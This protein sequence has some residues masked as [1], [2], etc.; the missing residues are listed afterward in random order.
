[1]LLKAPFQK[2]SSIYLTKSKM[3]KKN[4]IVGTLKLKENNGGGP[5]GNDINHLKFIIQFKTNNILRI[6]IVDFEE[7]R[8]QASPHVLTTTDEEELNKIFTTITTETTISN[9]DDID[10]QKEEEEFNNNNLYEIEVSSV[11]E[12]FYFTIKRK[13][14]GTIVFTTKNRPFVFSDQYITFG[15]ELFSTDIN[16]KTVD[17]D[18]E[19]NNEPNIYGLG[20]RIDSLRL[21]IKNNKYVMWNN[22]NGNDEK[23]N[24][25]GTHPFYLQA[26]KNH[27]SHGVFF[28]NTNAIDVR[29]K[30]NNDEKYLQFETIGGIIDL[31]LFL[32]PTNE[33]VIK[34]YH[35]IIGKS[36][37]PPYW[38]LGFHQCKWGYKN[39]KELESVVNNY[40]ENNLPLDVIWSDIDYMHEYWDFTFD[41]VNYPKELVKE[42]VNDL[43]FNGMK[44]VV[45]VDP[46][47]P[48][49][50]LK[51]ESYE[52]LELGL[53]LDIFIKNP[54][55]KANAWSTVWPGACYFPDTTNPNFSSSYWTPLIHKFLKDVPIDGL[56]I[57]MNE[58]ATFLSERLFDK[59][60]LPPY[61]PKS[62]LLY[63]KTL[64][65]NSNMYISNYYNAH[66]LYPYFQA[67]ATAEALQTFYNGKRSFVLTRSSFAG[68]GKYTS[69]WTGD[70]YSTYSSMRSSI[71]SILLHNMFGMSHVGA[72]IGG[73]QGD[74]KEELLIRWMQLGSMYPFSRNH[75]SVNQKAQEPY[76]FSQKTIDISRNVLLNRYRLLPYFYTLF[77]K[78][79]V[80]GGM[81]VKPLFFEFPEEQETY[82]IERQFLIGNYLLVSPVLEQ[83]DVTVKAYFPNAIWYD[84]YKGDLVTRSANQ[85]TLSFVELNAPIDVLPLHLRGGAIIPRQEPALNTVKQK[86]NPYE[87]LIALN[88]E[89]QAFGELFLDDGESLNTI[90][91]HNYTLLNYQVN[92]VK[93]QLIIQEI[94][95]EEGYYNNDNKL[96]FN[97]IK[98]YMGILKQ[99]KVCSVTVNGQAFHNYFFHSDRLVLEIEKMKLTVGSKWMVEASLC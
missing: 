77:A 58:L 9:D 34:Q 16:E 86:G 97:N 66:T 56:W 11:G 14:E 49:V 73:F 87:L 42:F 62:Q 48:K 13:E 39:L 17:N 79:S 70:N 88:N 94:V 67:K 57:D 85:S 3:V 78:V 37:L 10:K 64:P 28:L 23:T 80:E 72:D 33:Q 2:S 31:F 52:P 46:G 45:I 69:H 91:N 6:K 55:N 93:N 68:S 18:E 51:K 59:F 1:M 50:D 61:N 15:T 98:V 8:W 36:Y 29:T 41:S 7:K 75:N 53:K 21:D 35:S 47:I 25:Y 5:F 84:Y 60:N 96:V 26:A 95:K 65:L 99:L 12:P 92:N 63:Y 32:G 82:R 90:E 71:P 43:H 44:Y 22:D 4:G 83:G 30:F 74:C 38:S 20:E 89:G 40:K 27:S 24:L 19:G 76:Q 54:T 81:V